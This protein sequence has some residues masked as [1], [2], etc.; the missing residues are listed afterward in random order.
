[1]HKPNWIFN[2]WPGI[3][4]SNYTQ[5]ECPVLLFITWQTICSWHQWSWLNASTM[6]PNGCKFTLSLPTGILSFWTSGCKNAG[7][8]K[9]LCYKGVTYCTASIGISKD[10]CVA[11][12]LSVHSVQSSSR[13][14]SGITRSSG[15]GNPCTIYDCLCQTVNKTRHCIEILVDMF[16][17]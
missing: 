5:K 13:P 10:M 8:C 11:G 4:S 2:R 16:H 7:S 9:M 3:E 14:S 1:M 17:K 15:L 12:N 6:E